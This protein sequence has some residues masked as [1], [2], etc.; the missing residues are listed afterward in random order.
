M[1]AGIDGK[2]QKGYLW[3]EE[4]TELTWALTGLSLLGVVANLYKR[5]WCFYCWA[6]TNISWAVVDFWYGIYAQSALQATY[7][8]L[9]IWGILKWK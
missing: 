8:G 4:M 1:A 7:F 5:R 9:A 2:I 6:V 3:G